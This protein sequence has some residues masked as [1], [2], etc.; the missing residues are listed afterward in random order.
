MGTR[1]DT[2]ANLAWEKAPDYK[3][4]KKKAMAEFFEIALKVAV[5]N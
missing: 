3:V 5:Q 1:T 2:Y 4:I